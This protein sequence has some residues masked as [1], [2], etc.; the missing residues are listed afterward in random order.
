MAIWDFL[1]S[2]MKEKTPYGPLIDC[3]E[4]CLL[5]LIEGGLLNIAWVRGG[6]NVPANSR[7]PQN[8]VKNHFF[9]IFWKF[10]MN[11]EKLRYLRPLYPFFHGEIAIW[12]KCEHILPPKMVNKTFDYFYGME[13]FTN[14]FIFI[15]SKES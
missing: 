13:Q 6:H 7:S 2:S 15:Q 1:N 4:T 10:I 8:T 12:K 9:F 5:T 14:F 11:Q 3:S